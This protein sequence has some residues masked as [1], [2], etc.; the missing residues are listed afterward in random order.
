MGGRE[1]KKE[2]IQG[3][4]RKH[5]EMCFLGFFYLLI[6]KLTSKT[7]FENKYWKSIEVRLPHRFGKGKKKIRERNTEKY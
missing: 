1:G 2:N 6:I 3:R 4:G 7:K 5:V